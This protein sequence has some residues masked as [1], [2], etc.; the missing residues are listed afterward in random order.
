M[1]PDQLP[2]L[3]TVSAPSV[4]PSGDW[5]VVSVARPDFDIDS[6]LSQLWRVPRKGAPRRITRG[7]NDFAPQFSPDGDVIGF[8]RAAGGPPQV[9]LVR[10][11]GGEP[12]VIT[13]AKLG[14]SA[15]AFS[16]DGARLVYTTRVPEQGRYGTDDDIP[17]NLEDPRHFTGNRLQFNGLGWLNGRPSQVF[18][19]DV[20][21]L[22][23]EPPV[24]PKGRAA[25]AAAEAAKESG[26][27][28]PNPLVPVA[29]RLT[30]DEIDWS[31]PTFTPDGKAIIVSGAA[32]D[33]RE[34]D[35]V[36][37]LYRIP[38]T[39]KASAPTGG[40][41]KRLTNT[42]R[43]KALTSAGG[44]TFS[45]NAEHLF[46]L[47]RDLGE[48]GLDFVGHHGGVWVMP[49]EGGTATQLTDPAVTPDSSLT[50]IGDDAV[51]LVDG[52]RGSTRLLKVRADGDVSVVHDGP[53]Y[54]LGAAEAGGQLYA[55][56][57]DTGS[58]GDVVRI[59]GKGKAKLLTD[60]CADLREQTT[61]VEPV[62]FTATSPDG[63]P[64]HGWVLKP[65]G[66]GPHPVLLNIHGGPYAAYTDHYF[67][68]FQVYVEAGYAVVACN[69]RGSSGYGSDHGKAIKGDMGNLD[70]VDI[71]SFLDQAVAADDALDGDRV[72]VMGGSY[73]GYMT[74]WIIAH[75]HRWA[76]A[77]VERGFLDGVS[78][79]GSSDIGWFFAGQYQGNTDEEMNRQSPMLLTGQVTTPT[80]VLH[81]ELDLRCPLQQGLT[82]YARL[83]QAGVD[84]E[85]LVFPGEN[86][87]LSRSGTPW[88]R[89][90]RFEKILEFWGK[91][92]PVNA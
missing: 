15:F 25:K 17:A 77:I 80:L 8:L 82:Y 64:V 24:K 43:P 44:A 71:L 52:H 10:A 79:V 18:L 89:R 91:H 66:E 81:S 35:L 51:L 68:E 90:Q 84:A 55:T 62:E 32:H 85:I 88:H 34:N 30:D 20:P 39:G 23:A 12:M 59:T 38:I 40:K 36:S 72:G 70:M 54:V 31:E 2:L 6:S 73:G 37:D 11:D 16:P 7:L 13:D 61:V 48:D 33:S 57:A 14:V 92:L 9:A 75:D 1:R 22:D 19:I 63:T 69:P 49:A 86:H 21:D 28:P 58:T 3:R 76:G 83:K 5:A 4:H 50:P 42:G 53:H 65:S 29:A 78:F 26:E 41:P 27:T 47:A 74:A 67:D 45:N 87:E 46:M 60:F 56:V